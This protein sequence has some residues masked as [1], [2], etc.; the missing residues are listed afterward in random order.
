MPSGPTITGK[1]PPVTIEV[2]EFEAL[3][4]LRALADYHRN[5]HIPVR[6]YQLDS[7]W[8]QKGS[9]SGTTIWRARKDTLPAGIEQLSRD[10]RVPLALHN[11]Y[12]SQSTP[13]LKSGGFLLG[14]G[15]SVPQNKS[16]Y[17]DLFHRAKRWDCCLYE[18]DWLATQI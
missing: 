17:E 13:S 10:L 6:Y 1:P 16:F 11:R 18:Q 7:W 12:W 5:S 14:E 4:E 8:Y 9:D 15:A 2:S 3:A